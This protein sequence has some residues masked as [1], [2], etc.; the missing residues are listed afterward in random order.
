MIP[1]RLMAIPFLISFFFDNRRTPSSVV[2]YIYRLAM[3]ELFGVLKRLLR[4]PTA[5]GM[6]CY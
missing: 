2:H 4:L 3:E 6:Y 5:S 1:H